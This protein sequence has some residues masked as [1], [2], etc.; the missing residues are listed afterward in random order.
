M[1]TYVFFYPV[2]SSTSAS[3]GVGGF[4]FAPGASGTASGSFSFPGLNPYDL[5]SLEFRC[6]DSATYQTETTCD[7]YAI[8]K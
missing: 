3:G 1:Q 5:S 6:G 8:K 4:W 2:T 7:G